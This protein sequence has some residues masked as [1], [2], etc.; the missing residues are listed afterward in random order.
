MEQSGIMIENRMTPIQ[1]FQKRPEKLGS[2]WDTSGMLVINGIFIVDGM[3]G[4]LINVYAPCS[5]TE[6][7]GLWDTIRLL[8]DQY[9][10]ACI[11]VAGDF[12]A[13]RSPEER[14]GRGE[15]R[16]RRDMA[17]FDDFIKQCNLVDMP[18]SGRAFT[19]YQ[20]NGWATFRLKEK[21]KILRSDLKAWNREV[22]RMIDHNIG[23]KRKE[24]KKWDRIDDTFGLEENE[25]IE[26]NRCSVE[27]L[28]Y[29]NWKE[30]LIFKR[31]K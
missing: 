17:N 7:K 22:F 30:N 31:P 11:C 29:V 18:L 14:V 9:R 19:C 10:E 20:V 16:D 6:K 25:V 8:I 26:R 28:R 12:N 24:I 1:K 15:T 2:S 21:L 4:V 5:H 27:L 23:E 3:R 13:I